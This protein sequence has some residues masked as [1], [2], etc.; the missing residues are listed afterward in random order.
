MGLFPGPR[1]ETEG[2]WISPGPWRPGQIG[3]PGPLGTAVK[4]G[5]PVPPPSLSE[6][7]LS[8]KPCPA[9]ESQAPPPVLLQGCPLYFPL[10]FSALL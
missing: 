10:L 8:L 5:Q 9:P 3:G 1:L 7:E 4:T 6:S 2:A